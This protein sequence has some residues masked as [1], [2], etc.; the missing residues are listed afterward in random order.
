MTG[1]D[2][3]GVDVRPLAR[4]DLLALVRRIGAQAGKTVAQAYVDR[5]AGVFRAL[6][7]FPLMGQAR[8]DFG[9]GVRSIAVERHTLII[10]LPGRGRVQ[11]LRVLHGGQ[12]TPDQIQS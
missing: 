5:I 6:Q 12:D 2:I 9:P 11:I 7:G 1:P 4:S 3:H 8:P 10:Y